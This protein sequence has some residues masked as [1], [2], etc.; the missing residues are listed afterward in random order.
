LW[1][2]NAAEDLDGQGNN[3]LLYLSMLLSSEMDDIEFDEY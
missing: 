3:R 1:H 2:R